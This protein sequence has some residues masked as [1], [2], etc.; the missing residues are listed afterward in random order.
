MSVFQGRRE[1]GRIDLGPDE[2]RR[3][4]LGVQPLLD[5]TS[6][7]PTAPVNRIA[8]EIS[9]AAKVAAGQ[10]SVV[11]TLAEPRDAS[12]VSVVLTSGEIG[13]SRVDVQAAGSLVKPGPVQI[14]NEGTV[15]IFLGFQ[16]KQFPV[17]S[18]G[19]I[20]LIHDP[21][22]KSYAKKGLVCW[23]ENAAGP[24]SATQEF[25]YGYVAAGAITVAVEASGSARTTADLVPEFDVG[26]A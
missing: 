14:G 16:G 22:N 13:Q 21:A 18:T 6:Q 10:T 11:L 17:I 4:Y 20:S 1:I 15:L 23:T 19:P 2:I 3:V 5:Q 26:S 24:E 9:G 25:T 12:G 8:P 7:P